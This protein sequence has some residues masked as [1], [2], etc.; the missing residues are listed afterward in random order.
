MPSIQKSRS[1]FAFYLIAVLIPVL[2]FVLLEFGLRTFG[3]GQDLRLFVPADN[4]LFNEPYMVTNPDVANRYFSTG[5][6]TPSPP[7]EYFRK[8]KPENGYRIFVM[9]GSTTAGW[10]YPRNIM[11]SRVLSQRLSDAFPDKYIEVI[12]TGIAAVNTFTLLDFIDEILAQKPDAI[13]IYSGHNEF[14]GA[15]GAGSTQSVGQARWI[16]KAYLALSKLKTF[17]LLR[18]LVDSTRQWLGGESK[19]SGHATLMSQMVGDSSIA[20]GSDTY[21]NARKNF[22]A[23]LDEI[24]TRFDAAGVPVIVS[25][26]VSNLKDMPPFISVDDGTHLPADLVYDWAQMLD[27]E[28][29]YDMARG[30]YTWAK[31]LDGLRFRAPEEFNESIHKIAAR[32]HAPVVPMK[33]YFE[34]VARNGIIGNDLMLEHLHPNTEGYMLM[35]DA[36]FHTMENSGLIEK[37]WHQDKLMLDKFYHRSWPVTDLDR[38]LGEIRIINLTDHYP[39]KPKGP[40]ERT[41]ANYTPRNK[42]EET[43]LAVFKNELSYADGHIKMAE[44]YQSQNQPNQAFHEYLAL[45]SAAP[46]MVDFYLMTGGYLV[47]QQQFQQAL[48]ILKAS[49]TLKETGFANK[50]VGQILLIMQ[51]PQEAR[52]YFE[53]ALV[54]LPEDAQTIYNLGFVDIVS[55]NPEGARVSLNLLKKFAPNSQQLKNLDKLIAEYEQRQSNQPELTSPP[56]KKEDTAPAH[57]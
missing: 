47:N 21:N 38:A 33:M 14:Y 15:L 23:N 5:Y 10:P 20:Y 4:K 42:V 27:K 28:G 43:A 54:D 26:L 46:Y 36:F 51:R 53:K 32:H 18:N 50:W 34:K 8:N 12:N 1:N 22:E 44:Y 37:D 11:F 16:I 19:L 57:P 17:Q 6:F 52:P 48:P 24:L 13:L 45:I 25:D 29:M 2:F 55:N 35:S 40:G 49:L 3:Y 41:I 7:D 30:A 56:A 9:G 31:D 39:Y